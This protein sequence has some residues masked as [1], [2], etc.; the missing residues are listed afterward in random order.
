MQGVLGG[1]CADES[2]T[3]TKFTVHIIGGAVAGIYAVKA[4]KARCSSAGARQLLFPVLDPAAKSRWSPSAARS[5]AYGVR[6]PKSIEYICP[7]LAVPINTN[8]YSN[9]CCSGDKNPVTQGRLPILLAQKVSQRSSKYQYILPMMAQNC[10]KL[11]NIAQKCAKLV[12]HGKK[13]SKVPVSQAPQ[14]NIYSNT[15]CSCFQYHNTNTC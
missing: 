5:S 7:I 11:L 15:C 10:S 4:R 13:G 6:I 1:Y 14:I 8:I 2:G 3:S 9:T 12:E